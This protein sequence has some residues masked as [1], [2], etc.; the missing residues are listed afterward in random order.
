MLA[1]AD[2]YTREEIIPEHF[3]LTLGIYYRETSN[4]ILNK[5][6][7]KSVNHLYI[8]SLA[9]C[10][11]WILECFLKLMSA[12]NLISQK[13]HSSFFSVCVLSW[14]TWPDTRMN[15]SVIIDGNRLIIVVQY[16]AVIVAKGE[17]T[18][19]AHER[20]LTAI[21]AKSCDQHI[22]NF[23]QHASLL[24]SLRLPPSSEL[25]LHWLNNFRPLW[26]SWSTWLPPIIMKTRV[27]YN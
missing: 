12:P 17:G 24:P 13:G 8:V 14:P 25:S 1:D 27:T 26:P 4:I 20:L 2:S 18:V 10:L 7:S 11:S 23:Y 15:A 21:A 3:A 16:L 19:V 9:S 6:Y 22:W 5:K